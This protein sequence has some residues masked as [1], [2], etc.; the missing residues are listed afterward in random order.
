MALVQRF[1]ISGMT[2]DVV[3]L[4]EMVKSDMKVN[5]LSDRDIKYIIGSKRFIKLFDGGKGVE[6]EEFIR[7]RKLVVN[8]LESEH[9]FDDLRNFQIEQLGTDQEVET[10]NDYGADSLNALSKKQDDYLKRIDADQKNDGIDNGDNDVLDTD[11]YNLSSILGE[12]NIFQFA[13]TILPAGKETYA[14][15]LIDTSTAFVS[16]DRTTFTWFLNWGPQKQEQGIIN[17]SGNLGNIASMRLG[18]AMYAN[19]FQADRDLLISKRIAVDIKEFNDE[20]FVHQNG[21]RF[22][23]LQILGDRYYDKYGNNIRMSSFLLNRGW[24][25]FAKHHYPPSTLTMTF[26][27]LM[28]PTRISFPTSTVTI[29]ATQWFQNPVVSVFYNLDV[30]RYPL[31]IDPPYYDLVPIVYQYLNEGH[32]DVSGPGTIRGTFGFSGFTTDDPVTDAAL[33]AAYNSPH[34]FNKHFNFYFVQ[35]VNIATATFAGP[36]PRSVPVTI[37]FPYSPRLCMALELVN[38]IDPDDKLT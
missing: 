3:K 13:R 14:Y 7:M 27:D 28:G 12:T 23:F 2:N 37:T 33:I 25:R 31:Q 36:Y 19:M 20:A 38:D 1:A 8:Y 21:E 16:D 17:L 22:H 32:W 30:Y 6:N 10:L 29:P 5:D 26:T 15:C 34:T 11:S 35:S 9:K 4:L 24:F 18:Q